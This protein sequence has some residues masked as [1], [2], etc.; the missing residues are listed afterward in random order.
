MTPE[1]Y[2][3]LE[4]SQP[5]QRPLAVLSGLWRR[6]HLRAPDGR[7]RRRDI[8]IPTDDRATIVLENQAIHVRV[9]DVSRSGLRIISG[10]QFAAGALLCIE[11]GGTAVLAEVRYSTSAEDEYHTGLQIQRVA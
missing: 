1:A 3:R 5:L 9:V 7:D 11:L 6:G 4:E 10:V 2:R 8:R